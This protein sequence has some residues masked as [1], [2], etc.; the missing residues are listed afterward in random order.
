MS[1][2]PASGA[3]PRARWTVAAAALLAGIA[4]GLVGGTFRRLLVE[5]DALRE[6]IGSAV[7]GLP[8]G[9]LLPIAL[10]AAAAAL[11]GWIASRVPLASGSGIQHVEAVERG[12]A[13]PAP[14]TVVP[15]RFVGGLVS[16]GL[17]GMVLGREGPTVHMAAALGHAAGRW[18]RVRGDDLRSLHAQLAGAGLAVA[19]NAPIGGALFAIEEITHAVRARDALPLLLSVG[20]AVAVS[21]LIMGDHPDFA[22]GPVA[23]PSI[24]QLPVFLVFGA[25]VGVLGVG[26][27]KLTMALLRAAD[28][29]HRVPAAVKA[30]V[31]GAAVGAFVFIDPHLVGGG[32]AVTALLVSGTHLALPTLAL[33]LCVRFVLGPLSYAAGTPG[34]LFAPMLA[35]GALT[36][37]AFHSAAAAVLPAELV[38]GSPV[39]YA[40]VGMSTLFAASVRAPLTGIALVAE[41]TAVTSVAVPMMLAAAVA[42]AIAAALRCAPIYDS[43]R[44]RML[45]ATETASPAGG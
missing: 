8:G 11:G 39:P 12:E 4:A 23:A 34:G 32:D 10:S 38:P 16:I 17:G 13:A 27:S 45:A 19:F 24:S 44:E 21:R 22:V 1:D 37:L 40:L 30:A 29:L 18:L 25:A 6:H 2:M 20:S 35:L 28:R 15:A 7:H 14:L 5:L 36:G 26:Y 31:I 41:M 33:Y 42:V 3:R 9:L 43:L